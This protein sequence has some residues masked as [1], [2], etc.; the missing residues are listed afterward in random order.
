MQWRREADLVAVD[1]SDLYELTQVARAILSSVAICTHLLL[2]RAH[3]ANTGI[4]QLIE[5]QDGASHDIR[6]I[7]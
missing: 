6:G 3:N 7:V 2:A 1:R 4:V 5:K